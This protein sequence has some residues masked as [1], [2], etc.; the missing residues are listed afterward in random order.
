MITS[1][2]WSKEFCGFSFLFSSQKKAETRN[3][4]EASQC[5][6][7][8]RST[9]SVSKEGKQSKMV[10]TALF[11]RLQFKIPH[12]VCFP[13]LNDRSGMGYFDPGSN[14]DSVLNGPKRK[15]RHV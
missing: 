10:D 7:F 13:Y 11:D 9:T 14:K 15:T 1:S 3:C 12:H 2:C 5:L 8:S 6:L 4:F